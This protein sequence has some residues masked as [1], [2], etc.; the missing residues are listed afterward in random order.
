MDA[1]GQLNAE[2]ETLGETAVAERLDANLYTGSARAVAL[3]WLNDKAC[4]RVGIDRP[5]HGAPLELGPGRTVRAENIGRVAVLCAVV[6]LLAS[7]G[8]LGLS[9]QTLQAVRALR[10]TV[11]SMAPTPAPASAPS[12]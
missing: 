7:V 1:V 6:A 2:F 9:V 5:A 3:R 10:V 11:Q 12:H 8:S 4:A